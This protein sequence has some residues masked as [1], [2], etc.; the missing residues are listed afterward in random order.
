MTEVLQIFENWGPW[1]LLALVV[2]FILVYPERAERVGGWFLGLFSWSSK[3]IRHRSIKLKIQGQVN[4]FARSIDRE[5][6]G[7]MPYNMNLNFVKNIDRSELDPNKKTVI[8]RMKDRGADDRNIVHSMMVY[9][10]SGVIPQARPYLSDAMNESINVTVTRKF[11]N[12]L[13][14]YSALQYLYDDVLPTC[15]KDIPELDD[16]CKIFDTLDDNGLFTRVILEEL[17]DY[18]ARVETRYPEESH[19]AESTNF[20]NYVYNVAT[21]QTGEESQEIGYLGQHI[22]TAFVFIGT[23]EHMLKKGP[24]L[25]LNHIRK[26]RDAGFGRAYLAARGGPKGRQE[27]TLSI[28]MAERVSYLAEKANLAKRNR[29]MH[30]YATTRD[31][32]TRIHILIEMGII[33]TP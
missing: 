28:D 23:A 30:Y 33:L 5:V 1:G 22:A 7:S 13:K 26:L 3:G 17:R 15:A 31:G 20:V 12:Y 19:R 2:I 10:P 6:T 27:H 9:C 25:Y 4:T 32:T 14:N 11:L 24:S 16:F 21:R 29:A 8:V 18:G